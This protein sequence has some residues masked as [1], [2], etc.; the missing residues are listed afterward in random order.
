MLIIL[1]GILDVGVWK[2]SELVAWADELMTKLDSPP[3]WL[4]KLSMCKDL[5]GAKE[6]VR[7]ELKKTGTTLPENMG[8]YLVGL[9]LFRLDN[10]QVSDVEAKAEILD[11][12][13]AYG[14][15][16][17]DLEGSLKIPLNDTRYDH[18]REIGVELMEYATDTKQLV[19]DCKISD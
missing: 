18:L 10:N 9:M 17:Y 2:K 5:T 7:T 15:T 11:L 6:V 14:I 1:F 3:Y 12:I 16:E 19:N 4:T 8:D 13:D